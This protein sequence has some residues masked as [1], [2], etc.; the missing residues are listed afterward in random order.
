MV[1]CVFLG[2]SAV[3][4]NLVQGLSVELATGMVAAVIGESSRH[5]QTEF[6]AMLHTNG[7]KRIPLS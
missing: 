2:G 6:E 1:V 4:T 5:Q 3:M 7:H